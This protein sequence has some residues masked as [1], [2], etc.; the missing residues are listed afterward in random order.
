MLA[1]PGPRRDRIGGI[2]CTSGIM[3]WL[4]WVFAPE[5][6]MD[7]GRPE[8]SVIRWILELF[9]PRSTEFGPVRSPR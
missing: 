2:P 7:R 3:A 9:L 6:P 1:P 5:M 4:S 8:R